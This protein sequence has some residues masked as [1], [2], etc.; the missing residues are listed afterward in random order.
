MLQLLAQAWD[1]YCLLDDSPENATA[2][3]DGIHAAQRI[4]LR[5]S[6]TDRP[7]ALPY[8]ASRDRRET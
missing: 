8:F 4:I 5:R 6:G 3:A 7:D 1:V 2:F